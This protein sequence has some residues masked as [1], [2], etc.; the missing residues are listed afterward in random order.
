VS[1]TSR[2]RSKN[3]WDRDFWFLPLW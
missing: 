2:Y 1:V 3:R